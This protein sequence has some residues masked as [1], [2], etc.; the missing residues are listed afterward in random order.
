MGPRLCSGLA[1]H[2]AGLLGGG[3]GESVE[4]FVR[5]SKREWR[6][7]VREEE[8]P[9]SREYWNECKGAAEQQLKQKPREH[10]LSPTFRR[11]RRSY[12]HRLFPQQGLHGVRSPCLLLSSSPLSPC[13]CLPSPGCSPCPAQGAPSPPP[14]PFPLWC[15]NV[16]CPTSPAN[17]PQPP[18]PHLPTAA[19]PHRGFSKLLILLPRGRPWPRQGKRQPP[20]S[21]LETL[22]HLLRPSGEE[23]TRPKLRAETSCSSIMPWR[24]AEPPL[25]WGRRVKARFSAMWRGGFATETR[26]RSKTTVFSSLPSSVQCTASSGVWY[27]T[28][29]TDKNNQGQGHVF[30]F[31]FNCFLSQ[32]KSGWNT[33]YFR[34]SFAWQ[35]KVKLLTVRVSYAGLARGLLH[36]H[37]WALQHEPVSQGELWGCTQALAR[38]LLLWCIQLAAS[39]GIHLTA[40]Q[41]VLGWKNIEICFF[42]DFKLFSEKAKTCKVLFGFVNHFFSFLPFPLLFPLKDRQVFFKTTAHLVGK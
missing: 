34:V 8:G 25:L 3:G 32:M 21:K 30:F 33:W 27:T 2:S 12:G 22:R 29:Q 39:G 37:Q 14:L 1:A 36:A 16:P 38:C 35:S 18:A 19:P 15:R 26:E 6:G 13:P 4:E 28:S 40:H 9:H 31:F 23:P 41:H 10:K 17:P 11:A 5:K 20:S 42:H 24:W 7:G